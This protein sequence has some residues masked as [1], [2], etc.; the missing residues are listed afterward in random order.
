MRWSCLVLVGLLGTP[1]RAD[2][3]GKP[4]DPGSSL[5]VLADK[6]RPAVVHVRGTLKEPPGKPGGTG[7]GAAAAPAYSVGSGFVVDKAGY[8]VT[9]EHVVRGTTNLRVRLHDGR[10]LPAC[11]L[12]V[13]E[14][15]DIAVL[16]VSPRGPLPVL[17]LGD[18]DAVRVGD[19][20][21]AI[22]SPFGFAHSVTSGIVSAKERVVDQPTERSSAS[23][24]SDEDPYSFFI[25]TDASINVG[26]SGGPLVS[27]RGEA[28]GVN[29]AFWGGAQP[30]PGVGFA[31][32]INV[33]KL[34]LPRLRDAGEAPRSYLGVESQPLTSDLVAALRLPSIRGA[35]IASVEPAS[36]AAAAG[37]EPG[38]VITNW[39]GHPLASRNDFRIFAQLT[40]PGRTAQL[41]L[42]REGKAVVRQVTTRPAE[43]P[44]RPRHM[45]D[46]R[47]Q[48]SDTVLA[49]GFEAQDV[50]AARAEGLPGRKGVQVAR[51]HGGAARE[52][53][54]Q[55]GDIILRVGRQ[56][57]ASAEELRRALDAW[58]AE[59]PVPLLVRR[60]GYPFWTALARK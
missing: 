3:A 33:V 26:N 9:N 37:I 29:A 25:Q 28:I 27:Q 47:G 44:T 50:P 56:P 1:G 4:R 54:L 7:R 11:V 2:G 36:A 13:D 53:D 48:A 46:C 60:H 41:T 51:V 34:L 17:P 32:P 12:G 38:D 30:A 8:V 43:N 45:A 35:L 49:E 31:I 55:P 20:A 52:A 6:A 42:I 15:A 14:P 10:E 23:G 39:D 58:Q 40:P 16:R 59:L 24:E 22:G 18:S 21:V 19:T 5:A 57:V